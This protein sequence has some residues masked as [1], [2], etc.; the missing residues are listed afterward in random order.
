MSLPCVHGWI[1][2]THVVEFTLRVW[3]SLPCVFG[4]VYLASVVEFT[5]RIWLS[6]PCECHWVYLACLVEFTLRVSLSLPCVFGWVYHIFVVEFALHV[7]LSLPCVCGQLARWRSDSSRIPV[8][9]CN[10]NTHLMTHSVRKQYMTHICPNYW[11][12][13]QVVKQMF[14][15]AQTQFQLNFWCLF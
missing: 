2:L 1:Y 9:S 3:L 11:L 5:L 10:T 6:L 4:W 15:R 12:I 7:W 13:L 8:L 14:T